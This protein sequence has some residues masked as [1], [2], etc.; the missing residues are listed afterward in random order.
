VDSLLRHRCAIP[1]PID[2]PGPRGLRVAVLSGGPSWEREPSLVSGAA[3]CDGLAEAGHTSIPIEIGLDGVWRGADEAIVVEPGGGLDDVD[4]VFPVLHG[5][6]GEDG[7]VQGLLECLGVPYVGSGV[8]ASAICLDKVMFKRLMAQ[9]GLPQIDH[10]AVRAEEWRADPAA[11]SERLAPLGLPV[12]VKPARLGSSFGVSCVEDAAEL[13]WAIDLAFDYDT[14]ALVEAAAGG[15]EVE[16]S[17]IG[18][19]DPHVAEPGELVVLASKSGWRDRE[20]KSTPGSIR[21]VVPARLPRAVLERIRTVA[22][23]AFLLTGCA[24]LARVDFFVDGEQVLINEINTMPG[25]KRTS[26]FSLMLNR[27]G[28]DYP[29]MLDRLVQLALERAPNQAAAERIRVPGG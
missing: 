27:E 21:I 5:P 25:L 3:V 8:L 26:V 7:K 23:E 15:I 16:C 18:N 1:E 10:R 13:P 29:R 20:T 11:V 28:L 22:A 12:F 19:E 17:V 6:F 4:V 14:L 24:G 2:G 9:A